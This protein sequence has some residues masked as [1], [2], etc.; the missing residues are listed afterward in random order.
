M[1]NREIDVNG[2]IHI[3]KNP[4]SK[5]GVFPY[6]GKNISKECEPN[7]IYW[8][9]R[10]AEELSKPETIESFRNIPIIDDH[11]MIGKGATPAERKGV[12]GV[13]GA[14]VTQEGDFL[15]ADLHIYSDTLKRKID[16]NGK[17]ELSMGYRVG[18][19]EPA[20][21]TFNGKPYDFIQRDLRGNHI[22]LVQ[23]G[24]M[25]KEVA[26]L[27][28]GLTFDSMD[29]AIEDAASDKSYA[30]EYVD[31][32]GNSKKEPWPTRTGAER[33]MQ[34][35][36]KKGYDTSRMK[37]I[38][39]DTAS[40]N[41]ASPTADDKGDADNNKAKGECYMADEDKDKD[42]EKKA[43]DK[44]AMDAE[45]KEKEGEEKLASD[46][47]AKDEKEA[48]EK[49][50]AEDKKAMDKKAKD[51]DEKKDKEDK[52]AEDAKITLDTALTGLRSDFESFKKDGIKAFMS[53]INHR[54]EIAKTVESQFGTFDHA[55]LT[56]GEVA[57]YGL[58]KA[59]I[60]APAG[61]EIAVWDGYS[62]GL[63]ARKQGSVALDAKDQRA[64]V[65]SLIE[66]TLAASK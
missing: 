35:L 21:G 56:A 62:K 59:G 60:T 66:K 23:E 46:K 5:V 11:T 14:N 53:E 64:P 49:K 22:A 29:L 31:K 51:E 8:V 27:D 48:D 10:P 37:I 19:Y 45:T 16:A 25:G 36:A 12:D 44:K 40:D 54:N 52:K 18:Y 55:E 58:K 7:K 39:Q 15:F 63:S 32:L 34:L 50:K 17:K 65:G 47:K 26:V 61:S 24:R 42:K 57:A 2:F 13:T 43:A 6:M 41:T 9:Y 20:N 1:S 3:K 28:G 30:V 4:I 38:V 33:Y